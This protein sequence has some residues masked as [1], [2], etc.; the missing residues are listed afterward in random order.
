M[1]D[2]LNTPIDSPKKRG[3]NWMRIVLIISLTLNLLVLGLVAGANWGKHRDHG[4]NP[5]G[6]NRSEVR[7]L[8]FAPMAGALNRSDRR[9]IGKALRDRSGSFSEN[10]AQLAREFKEMLLVIRAEPF[11]PAAL[12]AL[13]AQQSERRSERG[14]VAQMLL[15]ERLEQMSPDDRRAFADRVEK[16]VRKHSP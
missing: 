5:R 15:I 7:D 13:M 12:S 16:S 4:F 14:T 6:P 1:N 3:P 2:D 8:G 9:E 10:R 11:D